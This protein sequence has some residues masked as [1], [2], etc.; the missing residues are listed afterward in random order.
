MEPRSW[1]GAYDEG[2]HPEVDFAPSTLPEHLRDAF[3]AVRWET[4]ADSETC[5]LWDPAYIDRFRW[6]AF[7]LTTNLCEA[8]HLGWPAHQA[9]VDALFPLVRLD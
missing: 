1:H 9:L 7:E 5:P 6:D 2:V 8:P 3:A 4:E